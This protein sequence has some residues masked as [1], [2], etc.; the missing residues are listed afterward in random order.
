MA[1]LVIAA[2]G[3]CSSTAL[4]IGTEHTVESYTPG[5]PGVFVFSIDFTALGTNNVCF[6]RLYQTILVS[7]NSEKVSSFTAIGPVIPAI[8]S[9]IPIASNNG[10]SIT[11]ILTI[12]QM[13]G[14]LVSYPWTLFQ[15]E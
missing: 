2:S 3:T 5:S 11:V 14:T 9:T 1:G 12:E 15:I 13:S 4:I 7:G 6:A 8:K 10:S